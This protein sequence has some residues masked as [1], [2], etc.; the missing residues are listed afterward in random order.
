L[1]KFT[2]NTPEKEVSLRRLLAFFVLCALPMIAVA[3]P[4]ATPK[5]S[6]SPTSTASAS[7]ISGKP[8]V[9]I[10]QFETPSDLDPK[11]GNAVAN[12]Y[13]QVLSQ[14]GG[15]T[16]LALPPVI[17][18]EDYQT[19]AHIHHADYYVSG[20]IQPIGSGAA[21]VS[22][23]VDVNSD[24]SVYSATTQVTDVQDIGSAALNALSVIREASGVDRPQLV[25]EA[26]AAPDATASPNGASYQIS[27]IVGDLFKGKGHGKSAS[28]GPTA[29]PV[30]PKPPRGVIVAHLLG[31]AEA[32]TLSA[33]SDA[34][35][36]AMDQHY[37]TTL[38]SVATANLTNQADA[39]CGSNRNNTIASGVLN[40]QHVGGFHAH[41]S[42][43][44]TFNVYACFGAVLYTTQQTNNDYTRAIHDA[45]EAYYE[46][47]PQNNG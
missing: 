11:Y 19:Y 34:L 27:S 24:I 26:T 20:Y 9:M 44:F 21:I 31:N 17:K 23:V 25:S 18:R 33:G 37:K 14:S 30:P 6:P 40:V 1:S 38:T 16:V 43:T 41:D 12:I 32:Q 13:A 39:I 8:V 42:Y 5:P 10:F 3:A 46:D 29:T 7:P 22:Q 36:R 2:R 35:F 28:P 45:V 47:H 4:K 15:V